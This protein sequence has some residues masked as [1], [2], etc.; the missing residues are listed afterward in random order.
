MDSPLPGPEWP[1][2]AALTTEAPVSESASTTSN[3]AASSTTTVG[4]ASE[5]KDH[6]EN[7]TLQVDILGALPVAH[8]PKVGDA[9][10]A[11]SS[12]LLGVQKVITGASKDGDGDSFALTDSLLSGMSSP[13]RSNTPTDQ[14]PSSLDDLDHIIVAGGHISAAWPKDF[15]VSGHADVYSCAA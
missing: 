12:P 4:G 1:D 14:L 6:V 2:L 7:P 15:A 3:F 13:G 10:R 8:V 9:V 11:A 5:D